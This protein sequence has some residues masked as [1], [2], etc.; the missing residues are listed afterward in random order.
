[1]SQ[2]SLEGGFCYLE[3]WEKRGK[4]KFNIVK[5]IVDRFYDLENQQVKTCAQRTYNSYYVTFF[6]GGRQENPEDFLEQT[7]G[8]LLAV[9]YY[10]ENEFGSLA[11]FQ[12]RRRFTL[13][14]SI[15]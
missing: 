3:N 10:K 9:G 4:G 7:I 1:M 8:V 5:V 11:L 12:K 15:E 14:S 13:L 2:A 6:S